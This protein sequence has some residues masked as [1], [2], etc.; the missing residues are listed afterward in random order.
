MAIAR[1][2]QPLW[3][4]EEILFEN[5]SDKPTTWDGLGLSGT[6]PFVNYDAVQSLTDLQKLQ[7]RENIGATGTSHDPVTLGENKNG[8]SLAGQVLSNALAT[9]TTNGAMS[10]ADKLKMTGGDILV[11]DGVSATGTLTG[12]VLSAG[13]VTFKV[14]ATVLRV[15][16]EQK[17]LGLKSTMRF[18]AN[19][20]S[21]AQI[22]KRYEID[23]LNLHKLDLMNTQ[24]VQDVA[25]EVQWFYSYTSNTGAG[26]PKSRDMIGFARGGI[27]VFGG[28]SLPNTYYDTVVTDEG[29]NAGTPS[30]RYPMRQYSYGISQFET[31]III[32]TD[33]IRVSK[34]TGDTKLFVEGAIRTPSPDAGAEASIFMGDYTVVAD[35]ASNIRWRVKVGD[36]VID[37][38]GVEVI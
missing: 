22:V 33:A 8:L 25:G 11:S 15:G 20:G 6:F 26:S 7:A 29:S 18:G 36:K 12:R 34:I 37:L 16:G 2:R 32:G 3:Q 4:V 9:D 28:R 10:S 17:I 35:A 1:K 38:L 31:G 27:T 30:Y 23:S 14:D 5:L 19:D 21:T 24:N 13:N